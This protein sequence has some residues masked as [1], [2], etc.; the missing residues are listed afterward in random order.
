MH[1]ALE[2]NESYSEEHDLPPGL[3]GMCFALEGMSIGAA[4]RE[5][6]E[7]SHSYAWI[8]DSECGFNVSME[9]WVVAGVGV[10]H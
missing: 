2:E 3:D 9:G 5:P 7:R 10:S 4:E 1:A 6:V 8:P